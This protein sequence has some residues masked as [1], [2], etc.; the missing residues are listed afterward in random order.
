LLSK[1]RIILRDLQ[2]KKIPISKSE[3]ISLTKQIL[4]K[5]GLPKNS[6]LSVI[7]VD[8][9]FIKKLNLKYLKK[10]ATTDVLAFPLGENPE[11]FLGDI[12]ICVDSAFENSLVFKT[13]PRREIVLYL[14]H[15]ILHLLGYRDK[16]KKEKMIMESEQKKFLEFLKNDL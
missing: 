10:M 1:D 13:T 11:N 12:V 6:G 14:I 3:I 8:K 16:G 5:K 2:K 7:F 15:G 9:E 4:R